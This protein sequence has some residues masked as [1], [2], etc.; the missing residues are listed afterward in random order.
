MNSNISSNINPDMY[1]S[2]DLCYF[3]NKS[4]VYCTL[5]FI[6]T[7]PKC[8]R[9]QTWTQRPCWK[10]KHLLEP[11]SWSSLLPA[12]YRRELRKIKYIYLRN[13]TVLASAFSPEN[14][15][16]VW[17]V[18]SFDPTYKNSLIKQ[19]DLSVSKGVFALLHRHLQYN[20]APP[21]GLVLQM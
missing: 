1:L 14:H 17:D 3:P 13:K 12:L 9:S 10:F 2:F 15:P 5:R 6:L 8:R 19:S 16:N 18:C 7:A 11:V 21:A 4:G 20:T